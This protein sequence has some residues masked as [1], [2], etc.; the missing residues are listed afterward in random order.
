[1]IVSGDVVRIGLMMV[2]GDMVKGYA[3]VFS[4]EQIQKILEDV[5]C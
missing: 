1:M 4:R 5:R 3:G 2:E